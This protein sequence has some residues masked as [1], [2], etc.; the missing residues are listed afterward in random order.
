M[1]PSPAIDRYL[2]HIVQILRGAAGVIGVGTDQYGEP[3]TPATPTTL[4]IPARV[5]WDR[6]R[7]FNDAGEEV[8]ANGVVFLAN[9]YDSVGLGLEADF[10]ELNFGPQDRIVFEGREHPVLSRSRCEGWSWLD[11]PRSHWEIYIA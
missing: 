5:E 10:V 8:T 1:R 2:I 9:K 4:S 11:D 7:T 3:L 6:R